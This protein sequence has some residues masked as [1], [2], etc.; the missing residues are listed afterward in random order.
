[1]KYADSFLHTE[2]GTASGT[3]YSKWFDVSWANELFVYLDSTEDGAWSTVVTLER[4]TPYRTSA[5][6]K[7]LDVA[8]VSSTTTSESYAYTP[9]TDNSAPDVHNKLGMRVR[10]KYVCTRTSGTSLTIYS[11]IYA[12]RN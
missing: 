4:Y 6:I 9:E 2:V 7:I 1:M 3:T 10:F 5:P 8:T 11:T 12:K